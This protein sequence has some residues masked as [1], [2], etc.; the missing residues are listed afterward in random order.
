[1]TE[2]EIRSKLSPALTGPRIL[3][4]KDYSNCDHII[5]VDPL[6]VLI[7]DPAKMA[8]YGGIGFTFCPICGVKL[9]GV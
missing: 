3:P 7:S 2:S 9:E 5:G 8:K 4:D 1:M 6:G